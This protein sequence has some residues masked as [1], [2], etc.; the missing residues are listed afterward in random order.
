MQEELTRDMECEVLIVGLGPV[1]AALGALLASR[2]RSVIV[3]ERERTVYPLPRAVGFDGDVMRIFQRMGLADEVAKHVRFSPFYDFV[4]ADGQL[5][6]RYDRSAGGHP[7]SWPH[8]VTFYQPAVELL[9]REQIERSA[10]GRYLLGYAFEDLR[11]DADAVVARFGSE[12]G[13]LRIRASYLVGCDGAKSE[14]RRKCGIG[15]DNFGFDEPWLVVDFLADDLSGLPDRNMQFCDP[16]RPATYLQMGPGRYRWE[17]MVLESDPPGSMQDEKTI[18]RLLAERGVSREDPIE[19]SAVYRFHGLV[20]R[21]WRKGRVLLAGDSAHQTPP[22]A[23]QG[24]CSGL[25][26]AFNLAWKLDRVVKGEASDALLDSYEV[27]RRPQVSFIIRSAIELGR[28]VCTIDPERAALRN[29]DMLANLSAGRMPPPL[30][31]PPLAEGCLLAGAPGAGELFPQPVAFAGGRTLR[32]D[33][34][35]AG[36]AVLVGRSRAALEGVRSADIMS[37]PLDEDRVAPF[38]TAISAWLDAKSTDCVLVRP[39]FHVFGTGDA[40]KLVSEYN[41]MTGCGEAAAL[42]AS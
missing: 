3:V 32:F 7:S 36:K 12:T 26:D 19:R 4:A 14:V 39:D 1:G 28:I 30:T 10:A 5:L 29:A 24:L 37:I 31:Y 18:R 35:S 42:A 20:A 25:R 11:Q 15:L 38:A 21:Q 41:R 17:F 16:A 33:D 23:G 27:E 13:Q 40:G 9:L 22:F 8:N 34:L 6:L 2:G